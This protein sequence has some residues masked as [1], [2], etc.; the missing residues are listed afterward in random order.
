[1]RFQAVSADNPDDFSGE[2]SHLCVCGCVCSTRISTTSDENFHNFGKTCMMWRRPDPF[3]PHV[4]RN[5]MTVPATRKP[6]TAT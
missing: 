4:F 2:V 1:M 6:A 5:G 3:Q